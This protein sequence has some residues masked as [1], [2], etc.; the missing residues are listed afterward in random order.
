MKVPYPSVVKY[1]FFFSS[2]ISYFGFLALYFMVFG[3][4]FKASSTRLERMLAVT[5]ER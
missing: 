1:V 5:E 4:L 2:K 3:A